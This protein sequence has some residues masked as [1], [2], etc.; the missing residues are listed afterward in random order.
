MFIPPTSNGYGISLIGYVQRIRNFSY[1]I[2]FRLKLPCR[3]QQMRNPFIQVTLFMNGLLFHTEFHTSVITPA[4]AHKR[5]HPNPHSH[6]QLHSLQL[7]RTKNLTRH[8][9]S[10]K[11]AQDAKYGWSEYEAGSRS[12]SDLDR[13][14]WV[15]ISMD[16][17][18]SR[19]RWLSIPISMDLDLDGSLSRW[20]S[21]STSISPERLAALDDLG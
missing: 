7:D 14:R 19:S 2:S 17:D 21:I 15:S 5:S 1:A 18:G 4:A 9:C 11:A 13:P 16:L 20:I 12:R 6:T 10:L 3:Q 8:K